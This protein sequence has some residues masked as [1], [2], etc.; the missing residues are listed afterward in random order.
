MK[1]LYIPPWLR[2]IK[3]DTNSILEDSQY[4]LIKAR[5]YNGDHGDDAD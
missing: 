2:V 5:I 1:K 4:N 3:L